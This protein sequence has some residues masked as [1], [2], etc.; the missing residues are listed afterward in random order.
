MKKAALIAGL[1]LSGIVFAA[2]HPAA[3][4]QEQSN[5]NQQP[6]TQETQKVEKVEVEIKPGD[7]LT[8]IATDHQT[9]YIRLFD[10]NTHIKD[11]DVIYPGDKVRIPDAGEQLESRSLPA[12]VPVTAAAPQPHATQAASSTYTPPKQKATPPAPVASAGGDVWD[13]I[14][15]CESGGNWSINTGNGYYGGLQ[16]T[17]QSWR[18]VGGSGYPHQ[19]SKAEQISRAEMLRA[20]QGWGAWPACTRKLGLR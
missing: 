7:T 5:Q 3:H 12:D 4:A 8:A 16:F 6:S 13:K 17:L 20:R 10:A 2:G 9:T 18:G 11:P 15:Q 1:I 14:A 19:A